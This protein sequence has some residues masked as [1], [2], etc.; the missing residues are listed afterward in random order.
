[1]IEIFE[2]EDKEKTY[3]YMYETIKSLFET[4]T[5]LGA[6]L[7]NIT[8]IINHYLDDINWVGFYLVDPEDPKML[9]LSYFQGGVACNRIPFGRGV[10]GTAIEKN[11]VQIVENVH[12]F[13]GHI[14][15][16]SNTNSEIVIPINVNGNA[17]GV[18]DIDSPNFSRFSNDEKEVLTKIVVLI[19]EFIEKRN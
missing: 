16:D 9:V 6:N 2:T 1:M 18:L 15:C 14:A 12:D 17:F 10:C 3:K 19:E 7:A 5:N 11:E 4:E 8:A 13:A